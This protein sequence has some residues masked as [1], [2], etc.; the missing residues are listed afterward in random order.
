MNVAVENHH[1]VCGEFYLLLVRFLK[2][3]PEQEPPDGY[4]RRRVPK[5][6]NSA[7]LQRNKPQEN[8]P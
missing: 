8:H 1:Y 5:P 4:K 3:P 2:P 7:A 6:R